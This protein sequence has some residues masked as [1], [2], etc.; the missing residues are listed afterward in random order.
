MC[1]CEAYIY[2]RFM[3]KFPQA[4]VDIFPKID[5]ER[6]QILN[7]LKGF[8]PELDLIFVVRYFKVKNGWV[9]VETNP[10]SRD[11]L[12]GYEPINAS[13]HKEKGKWV[14]KHVKP[15]CAEWEDYLEENNIK[16]IRWVRNYLST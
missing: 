7:S 6:R 13:L 4:P 2:K 15:C 11:G 10:R 14:K 16:S 5:L 12:N 3:E 9:W 8:A 1:R